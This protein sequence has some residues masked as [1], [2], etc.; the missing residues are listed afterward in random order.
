M[1]N[2]TN[3]NAFYGKAQILFELQLQVQKGEVVALMGRNGADKSTTLK[4]ILGLIEDRSGAGCDCTQGT[5]TRLTGVVACRRHRQSAAAK[6]AAVRSSFINHSDHSTHTVAKTPTGAG[7]DVKPA[8]LIQH[9]TAC[10]QRAHHGALA[11][12]GNSC[13]SRC[14]WQFGAAR[15]C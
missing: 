3:L 9:A 12:D 10:S 2:V 8:K 11:A 4:S 13:R 15:I 7:H 14:A 1:L 6:A 5:E